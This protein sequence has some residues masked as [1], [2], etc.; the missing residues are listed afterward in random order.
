MDGNYLLQSNVLQGGCERRV[1]E[2]MSLNWNLSEGQ[3]PFLAD[4]KAAAICRFHYAESAAVEDRAVKDDVEAALER[5]MSLLNANVKN[6]S[7]YFLVEWDLPSATL[8]L[9]VTDERKVQ[10]EA[11]VVTCRFT[12]LNQQ[13]QVEEAGQVEACSGK[14]R[15]WAKDYLSTCTEFMN[16]SLVALYTDTERSRTS[17]L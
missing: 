3:N 10:D 4:D 8:R 16:Y 14:V 17:I 7:T 15:F 11:D 1:E 13:L 9:A 6:E 2:Y 12:L 5:A